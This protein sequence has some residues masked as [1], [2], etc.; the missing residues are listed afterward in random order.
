MN[1]LKFAKR[2]TI[3]C[4]AGLMFLSS[5][6]Q[7]TINNTLYTTSQLVNGILV[8]TGSGTTVSSVN[9]RGVYGVSSKYQVGYFTTA[10][11]TLTSLGF[12]SGIYLTTG[13]TSTVPLTLG[14]NPGSV[15][16]MSTGY[17]SGTA[18][19]IRS[20]NPLAGQDADAQILISPYNY[21]N[22]AILEFDFVPVTTNVS[23]RYTF[24]SEEYNDESGSAFAINYNCSAYNDKFA[25]LI[26]G[27]GISGGQGYISYAKNIARLANGSEVGINSVNDGIVGSSGS[28]QY[29]GLCSAENPGWTS[30]TPTPEFMGFVNGTQYN[31]NTHI[32]TASQ[33]G[34]TPGAT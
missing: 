3:S 21:Y 26:S 4:L 2:T 7:I 19:E 29:A 30:G 1:N 34:M 23:F 31:G 33:S 18:G 5:T 32:L 8:P 12:S 15:A 17:T 28:P 27:P 20:S 13:N 10:G 22:A 11:P 16:Q 9:F 24:A 25:F 6:A 14:T